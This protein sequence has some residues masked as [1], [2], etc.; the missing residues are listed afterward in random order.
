MNKPLLAKFFII[1]LTA[2][3]FDTTASFSQTTVT[4]DATAD[5]GTSSSDGK[6]A[7]TKNSITVD[8]TGAHTT[9]G[10]KY[11][12]Y[13]ASDITIS[14]TGGTITQ[15]K[16]EGNSSSY[17][18]KNI[19][20][21]PGE[22]G[23]RTTSGNSITWKGTAPSV[24]FYASSTAYITGITVTYKAGKKDA[25]IS[26]PAGNCEI[27]LGEAF[28]APELNN[29]NGLVPVYSVV[30]SPAGMA[31]ID[32]ATGK[33][34]VNSYGTATVTATTAEDETFK[35]G[36][37]SY[38][39]TVINPDKTTFTKV[40]SEDGLVVGAKYII[41]YETGNVALSTIQA[42][43]TGGTVAAETAGGT[44]VIN[45]KSSETDP[46][47][48]VLGGEKGSYTL[49]TAQG[50]LGRQADNGICVDGT[51]NLWDITFTIDGDAVFSDNAYKCDIRYNNYVKGF[52]TYAQS[53]T[54]YPHCQIYMKNNDNRETGSFTVSNAK[55][56]TLYMEKP[57]VMPTGATG[58][59]VT[60][61]D[62]EKGVVNIL[63]CYTAGTV[64]PAKT[65]LL[66]K[67]EPGTYTFAYAQDLT[68]ESSPSEN[69]LHGTVD[70]NGYACITGSNVKYYMLSRSKDNS[71]LGFFWG[72]ANGAPFINTSPHAYLATD[73]TVNTSSMFAL[74]GDDTDNTTSVGEITADNDIQPTAIYSITG[75]YAGTA[76]DNLPAGVYI[77]GGKKIVR[78]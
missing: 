49:T 4:F 37:A 29:P 69:M 7:L 39:L 63:Y 17:P 53:N 36:E 15:I 43:G 78:K 42:N 62:G 67:G 9:D 22:T 10:T 46:F 1:A 6:D 50:T 74:G 16:F 68:E 41:V 58:G 8:F 5:K 12:I 14:A 24:A 51:D 75:V 59:I 27:T 23:S 57:F 13:G 55:Y 64:V 38:T 44:A 30:C 20:L 18:A 77:K 73:G 66:V 54:E 40:T 56:T 28:D 11:R 34:T 33:L 2:M 26:F 3:F 70:A 45:I 48:I 25:G 32:A 76:T 31:D 21:K 19:T 72:A 71:T 35:A 52:L 65:G 60:A 47:E 61:A